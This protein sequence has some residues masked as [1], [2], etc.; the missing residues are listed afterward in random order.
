[1]DYT[2]VLRRSAYTVIMAKISDQVRKAIETCGLTRYRIAQELGVSESSLSRFMAGGSIRTELLDKLGKLLGLSIK[3]K[4]P[5]STRELAR[6]APRIIR[7]R[8]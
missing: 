8:R 5:K 2:C 4:T 1:M 3:A 6:T 7:K